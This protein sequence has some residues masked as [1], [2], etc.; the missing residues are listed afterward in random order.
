[1]GSE[2]NSVCTR[3]MCYSARQEP[4]EGT[5]RPSDRLLVSVRHASR[6]CQQWQPA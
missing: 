3:C 1:V 2:F 6:G 5:E 4:G